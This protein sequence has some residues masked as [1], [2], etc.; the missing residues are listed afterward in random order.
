MK[1]F[2][3]QSDG[4][5]VSANKFFRESQSVLR[6]MQRNLS[7]KN[8]GSN[9]RIKQRLKVGRVYEKVVNK[10]IHFRQEYSTRLVN[11][12]DAAVVT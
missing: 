5:E 10:S 11:E 8:I 7:W 9:R 6:R 1:T 3:V 2:A 12:F 4:V